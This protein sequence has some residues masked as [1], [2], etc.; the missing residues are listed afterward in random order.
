MS[1]PHYSRNEIAERGQALFER[2]ILPG[3]DAS[4]HGK[5]LVLDVETGDYEIDRDELAVLKRARARRP[6][7]PLY[8]LRIGY[9][10]AYRVALAL[11]DRGHPFEILTE[12]GFIGSGE[13]RADLS[14]RY[15]EE[16]RSLLGTKHDD[17]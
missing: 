17:R 2:E 11:P 10:T 15:K 1:H 13:G 9:P 8:L 14:I 5:F 16:L 6:E 3:L 4:A 7:A 12:T